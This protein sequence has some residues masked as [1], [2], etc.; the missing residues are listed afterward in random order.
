MLDVI[1][2]RPRVILISERVNWLRG[3]V[4]RGFF[5]LIYVGE[6]NLQGLI[7]KCHESREKFVYFRDKFGMM[8][9]VS[10]VEREC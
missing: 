7:E 10:F 3:R 9:N 1:T 6:R 2:C 8:K 5:P 4:A